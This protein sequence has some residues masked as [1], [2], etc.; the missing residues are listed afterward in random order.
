MSVFTECKNAELNCETWYFYTHHLVIGFYAHRIKPK[1]FVPRNFKRCVK[2]P[3]RKDYSRVRCTWWLRSAQVVTSLANQ[4]SDIISSRIQLH[5][6]PPKLRI[7]N[8]P[9][10]DIAQNQNT[11]SSSWGLRMRLTISPQ[12]NITCHASSKKDVRRRKTRFGL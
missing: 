8:L 11:S 4:A 7:S 2:K 10:G 5:K 1:N 12:K 9:R 6:R 3:D